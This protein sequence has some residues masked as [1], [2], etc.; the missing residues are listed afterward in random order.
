MTLTRKDLGATVLTALVVFV[1]AAS[2]Q[3]WNVWLVGG[4]HRWA[5]GAVMAL[6]MATC[7]LGTPGRDGMTFVLSALG[8]S[9]LGLGIVAIATGSLTALSFLTLVT[10]VLWGLATFRHAQHDG[11]HQ[12]VM[13]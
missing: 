5:A 2:H 12:P 9:A 8:T 11:A 7:A 1:F 3:G 13:H 10:V 4:S 6:G